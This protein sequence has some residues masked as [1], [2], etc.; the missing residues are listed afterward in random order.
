MRDYEGM[1][2]IRPDLSQEE[3][4]KVV[5][6][7]EEAITQDK[8]KLKDSSS[9]GKRQLAYEIGGY[10]EGYYQL[11]HFQLDPAMIAKLEGACKLNEY[12]LRTLITRSE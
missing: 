7:I 8:G 1:F 10:T 9:W 11:T 6:A 4:N 5:A 3:S 12:I 2:I